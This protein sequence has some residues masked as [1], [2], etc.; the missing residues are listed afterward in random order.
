[1][2][3]VLSMNRKDEYKPQRKLIKDFKKETANFLP[4]TLIKP[5][6]DEVAAA[7]KKVNV[8]RLLNGKRATLKE[9]YVKNYK[10]AYPELALFIGHASVVEKNIANLRSISLHK[11]ITITRT[12]DATIPYFTNDHLVLYYLMLKSVIPADKLLTGFANGNQ[13][14]SEKL[15]LTGDGVPVIIVPPEYDSMELDKVEFISNNVPPELQAANDSF[16]NLTEDD[17]YSPRNLT[18]SRVVKNIFSF[19]YRGIWFAAINTLDSLIIIRTLYVDLEIKDNVY[20]L[21]FNPN[22]QQLKTLDR[23]HKGGFYD[24]GKTLD[25]FSNVKYSAGGNYIHVRTRPKTLITSEL[26]LK[27]K[28]GITKPIDCRCNVTILIPFRTVIDQY[29]TYESLFGKELWNFN[30]LLDYETIGAL[31]TIR[32]VLTENF[33]DNILIVDTYK[34]FY[35]FYSRFYYSLRSLCFSMNKTY[36]KGVR[37]SKMRSLIN[38]ATKLYLILT[39]LKKISQQQILELRVA[40]ETLASPY[41]LNFLKLDFDIVADYIS[42]FFKPPKMLNEAQYLW[43]RF[44]DIG[45]DVYPDFI[46]YTA[47]SINFDLVND[48]LVR[49]VQANNVN[50]I[51]VLNIGPVRQNLIAVENRN[52]DQIEN[53]AML[54]DNLSS[55]LGQPNLD[56]QF[57][58]GAESQISNLQRSIADLAKEN[59]GIRQ[60]IQLIDNMGQKFVNLDDDELKKLSQVTPGEFEQNIEFINPDLVEQVLNADENIGDKVADI[61]M[62]KGDVVPDNEPFIG[63]IEEKFLNARRNREPQE[64]A[65]EINPDIDLKKS[66]IKSLMK[67]SGLKG[68][69]NTPLIKRPVKKEPKKYT[70]ILG[71]KPKK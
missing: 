45:K 49:E 28:N 47:Y 52:N 66:L 32:N 64:E 34:P 5:K 42:H 50:F 46:P 3:R 20:E 15:L 71:N 13:D 55:Q 8:E 57:I 60:D 26:T 11:T 54:I 62:D 19:R 7:I 68:T 53:N 27:T 17:Y 39:M 65:K 44:N 31:P 51:P 16:F 40:L 37:V 56:N 36:L 14:I 43:E 63:P 33:I 30:N 67:R 61:V 58:D 6:L 35:Q 10:N 38:K 41:I 29:K 12:F 21:K 22:A 24:L 9:F 23:H 69:V 59:V 48:L 2:Q 1:M 25:D 18:N 4:M 70:F